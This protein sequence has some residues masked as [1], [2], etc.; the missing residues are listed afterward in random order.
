MRLKQG[1]IDAG[2]PVLYNGEKNTVYV[3]PDYKTAIEM[4]E[5]SDEWDYAGHYSI[6]IKEFPEEEY[7]W[8]LETVA[9]ILQ[10]M[11]Q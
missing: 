7:K 5:A 10:F 2:T 11:E 8:K 6:F 4:L 9:K 3:C 1:V